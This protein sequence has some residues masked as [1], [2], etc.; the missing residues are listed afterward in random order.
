MLHQ[1]NLRLAS[2]CGKHRERA[3]GTHTSYLIQPSPVTWWHFRGTTTR[4]LL[5]PIAFV[6]SLDG[7]LGEPHALE[8]GSLILGRQASA[9]RIHGYH[10]LTTVISQTLAKMA[11]SKEAFFKELDELD[12]MT[13][14]DH[15]VDDSLCNLIA[16]SR[17]QE[18]TLSSACP[19]STVTAIPRLARAETAPE[20]L[21]PVTKDAIVEEPMA[22]ASS[23]SNL[24][25]HSD[26]GLVA[27][28]RSSTTGSLSD[29][30]EATVSKKRRVSAHKSVPEQLQIFKHLTFCSS[31]LVMIDRSHQC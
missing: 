17:T 5:K 10:C 6:N 8:L 16:T 15:R 18:R 29:N 23:S 9:N 30:A 11:T 31:R 19:H 1:H 3:S 26:H 7:S 21:G 28:K 22:M 20:S 12:Y 2:T 27:V 4:P 14:D 25:N 13:D 24:P